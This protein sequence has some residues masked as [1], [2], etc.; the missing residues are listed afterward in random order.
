MRPPRRGRRLTAGEAR[1]W[2][3]IAKLVT[4]LAGRASPVSEPTP[5]AP[6]A[7]MPALAAPI[8]KPS[9]PPVPKRTRAKAPPKPAP[10]P[11]RPATAAP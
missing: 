9:A 4:P 1:L 6:T 8:L 10:E 7:T 5:M 2:D 11:P 3:A